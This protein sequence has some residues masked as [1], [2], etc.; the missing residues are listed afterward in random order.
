MTSSTLKNG[1]I[2]ELKN[3]N[4]TPWEKIQDLKIMTSSTLKNDNIYEFKNYNI[5][6]WKMMLIVD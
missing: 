5:T 6:P 4:L 3:Y 1:N 2:H